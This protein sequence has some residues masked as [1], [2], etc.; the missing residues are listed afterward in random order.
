M[1]AYSFLTRHG[2][3]SAVTAPVQS[4]ERNLVGML[5]TAKAALSLPLTATG[6]AR[7]PS[8]SR[9]ITSVVKPLRR[10]P[11]ADPT[12]SVRPF[13]R[14]HPPGRGSRDTSHL[15]SRLG[16]VSSATDKNGPKKLL[17][18]HVLS[19]RLKKLSNDG[20]LDDAIEMLKNSPLDAQ[21]VPVWNTMVWECLKAKRWALAYKLYTDVSARPFVWYRHS[22]NM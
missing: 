7:D 6:I 21:N 20:K 13:P 8:S 9:S 18:P 22:N 14:A 3:W 16:T 19:A 4:R 15:K 12:P 10:K 11:A 1:C 2:G 17:Q 5:R